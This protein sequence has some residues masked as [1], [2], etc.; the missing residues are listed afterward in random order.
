MMKTIALPSHI[1]IQRASRVLLPVINSEFKLISKTLN[2][3]SVTGRSNE[4]RG[5]FTALSWQN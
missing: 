2:T 3:P 4:N 5:I 1:V